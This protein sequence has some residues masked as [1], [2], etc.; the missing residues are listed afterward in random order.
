M[1]E[2]P[3]LVTESGREH[4]SLADRAG[5]LD[6]DVFSLMQLKPEYDGSNGST[7]HE[8]NRLVSMIRSCARAC[9]DDS[10]SAAGWRTAHLSRT[11]C[12]VLAWRRG[13][14]EEEHRVYLLAYPRRTP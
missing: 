3:N 14:H 6:A 4:L 8:F 9:R 7:C 5:L 11:E 12:L 10:P 13:G 1:N 2:N